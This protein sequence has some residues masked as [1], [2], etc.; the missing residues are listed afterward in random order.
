[1]RK[2]VSLVI[3]LMVAFG[4]FAEEGKT[5][6][7][8][9]GIPSINLGLAK[10]KIGGYG[11][12]YGS[13]VE[14]DE[15]FQLT[16]LRLSTTLEAKSKKWGAWLLLNTAKFQSDT[17]RNWLMIAEGWVEAGNQL[18]IH[19]GRIFAAGSYTTPIAPVNETV[20]YPTCDPTGCFIWGLQLEKLWGDE[21]T[22]IL[23]LA[24]IGGLSK[25]TAFDDPANWRGF[26]SS[27]RLQK[28]LGKGGNWLAGTAQISED[29][30]RLAIDAQ[31]HL[32]KSFYLRGALYWAKNR[33]HESDLVGAYLMAVWEPINRVEFHGMLDLWDLQ[34]KT[35]KETQVNTNKETGEVS[36][37][38][39]ECKS[40][41]ENRTAITLGATGYLTKDRN[42]R[43][44]L[45]VVVP[46]DDEDA[47]LDPRV[48]GRVSYK[49]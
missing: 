21:D 22:G 32:A 18:K 3:C 27:V 17:D 40:S 30:L 26:E 28:N 25:T 4:A 36:L 23:L 46:M 9:S 6:E 34:A 39:V 2:V 15:D 48:E 38:R 42:L 13:S 44:T 8:E 49:F 31:Y 35:W 47:G 41:T 16:D 5:E 20:S 12:V 7:K 1:M 45:D 24:D 33:G 11:A 10:V 14:G 19:A 43:A 29:Y 37:D